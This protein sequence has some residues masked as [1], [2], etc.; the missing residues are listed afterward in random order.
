[1]PVQ[2]RDVHAMLDHAFSITEVESPKDAC[3]S[4]QNIIRHYRCVAGDIDQRICGHEHMIECGLGK[5]EGEVWRLEGV[6]ED[7]HGREDQRD[8]TSYTR[9]LACANALRSRGVS[10]RNEA[11]VPENCASLLVA[12]QA[13]N[14]Q[15]N[16]KLEAAPDGSC[17]QAFQALEELLRGGAEPNPVVLKTPPTFSNSAFGKRQRTK[18]VIDKDSNSKLKMSEKAKEGCRV[19][20]PCQLH[21]GFSGMHVRESDW[22]QAVPLHVRGFHEDRGRGRGGPVRPLIVVGCSI[23]RKLFINME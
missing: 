9:A 6:S 1:M 12:S 16:P 8:M 20:C 17:T 22:N 21:G 3:K 23:S 4:M 15:P 11:D 7:A 14:V 13:G 19:E 18:F 10:L 5:W 2:L